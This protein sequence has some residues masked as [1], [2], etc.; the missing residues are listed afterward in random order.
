MGEAFFA[1]PVVEVARDLLGRRLRHGLVE[2]RITEVEAYLGPH[3]TAAHSRSGRTARNAAMWGPVGRAYVYRCYGLHQ[4]L[5]LVAGSPGGGAA[6]LIRSAEVV[7]GA[8][9]VAARRGGRTGAD[10]VAGPGKVAAALAIDRAF[11]HHPVFEPEG[12]ELHVGEPVDAALVGPRVGIGY[13]AP[14]DRDADLRF[15]IAGTR[16][17]TQ[18]R[19]LRSPPDRK[20]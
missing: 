9:L 7:A 2:L 16:A 3:D 6:I 18:R 15:A 11:D 5:N 10:A 12:L 1:R 4:M 20:G 8:E 19:S 13:A 17:V 14:A